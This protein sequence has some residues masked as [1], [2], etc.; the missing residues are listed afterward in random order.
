MAQR[1]WWFES[2]PNHAAGCCFWHIQI[3]DPGRCTNIAQ[4]IMAA[5]IAFAVDAPGEVGNPRQR[6]GEAV[7]LRVGVPPPCSDYGIGRHACLRS[8]CRSGVAGS[9]PARSIFFSS[10]DWTK[11]TNVGRILCLRRLIYALWSFMRVVRC[12]HS[13]LSVMCNPLEEKTSPMVPLAIGLV[14]FYSLWVFDT[15]APPPSLLTYDWMR[16]DTSSRL[17]L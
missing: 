10:R 2:I 14:F 6:P 8:R 7:Q 15:C 16:R 1:H 11:R 4:G 12:P 13:S 5:L 9:S 17:F 3:D